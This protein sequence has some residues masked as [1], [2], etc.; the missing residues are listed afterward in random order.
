MVLQ[1][2]RA[3]VKYTNEPQGQLIDFFTLNSERVELR[4]RSWYQRGAR[5]HR[6]QWE[7][8]VLLPTTPGWIT[9]RSNPFLT[10]DNAKIYFRMLLAEEKERTQKHAV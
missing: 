1:T 7:V 3:T 2:V 6:A 9:L 8:Y 4:K 10:E 5:Q